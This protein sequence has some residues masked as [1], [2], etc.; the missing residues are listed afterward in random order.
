MLELRQVAKQ[1]AAPGGEIVRAVDDVTVTIERGEI[2]AL[3]GPSGSGKTTVLKI[4]AALLRPDH[5]TV[6]VGG[7]D[8]AELS[9]REAARYRLHEVGFIRQL[10]DFVPGA[11]AIDNAALKLFDDLRARDARRR[12]EPLL[13]RLGLAGRLRHR[14]EQLSTGERQRVLIARALSTD[15]T[16]LLADEPTGS[17]DSRRSRDVLDLLRQLSHE[18]D[19]ATLL[20]THDPQAVSY[21]DRA[22]E[23]HDGRLRSYVIDAP[24][25]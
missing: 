13:A 9:A 4:V 23:L 10:P 6:H 2:V 7:R 3:Y 24:D 18:H 20:V 16:V 17:L 11:S 1:F 15:P 22:L 14:A 8:V 25:R 12:V 21:A 5:G 19:V